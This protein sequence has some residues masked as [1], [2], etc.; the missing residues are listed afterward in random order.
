MTSNDSNRDERTAQL[1]DLPAAANDPPRTDDGE[2]DVDAIAFREDFEIKRDE[3]GELLPKWEPIPGTGK[4]VLVTPCTQ[5]EADKY[6]PASGDARA[7]DDN[8]IAR[9][10]REFFVHPDFSDVRPTH[11]DEHRKNAVS[12][13]GGPLADFGAFGV[14]P[15]LLAWM[16]ASNFDMSRGL[17]AQNAEIVEAIEGNTKTGN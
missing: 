10:F 4:H 12:D 8:E 7:L 6:L 13:D 1:N 3:D 11:V 15:L 16:N 2:L 17:V 14:D 5:G 9:I